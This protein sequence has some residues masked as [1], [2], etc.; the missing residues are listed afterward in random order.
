MCL[1]LLFQ[2]DEDTL[3]SYQDLIEVFEDRIEDGSYEDNVFNDDSSEPGDDESEDEVEVVTRRSR[4]NA[5]QADKDYA[6]QSARE[7]SENDEDEEGEVGD[8]DEAEEEE[9]ADDDDVVYVQP[10]R[11]SSRAQTKTRPDY[12]MQDED[13]LPSDSDV[14]M[15]SDGSDESVDLTMR[16]KKP[17]IGRGRGRGRPRKSQTQ[18]GAFLVT[19]SDEEADEGELLPERVH[20]NVSERSARHSA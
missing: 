10:T 8:E 1:K 17:P 15:L 4:R 14:D 13:A 19:S 18:D 16:N 20:K 6:G 11:R 3:H 2:V 5:N 7:S 9:E 12:A